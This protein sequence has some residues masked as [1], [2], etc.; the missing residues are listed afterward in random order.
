MEYY[1]TKYTKEQQNVWDDF[2]ENSKNGTFLLKRAYMDYHSDRFQ[3]F[4]LFFYKDNKLIALLPANIDGSVLYS[5]QGLTYGGMIMSTKTT[6][7][8]TIQCFEQLNVFL[9]QNNIHKLIYKTIPYIYHHHPA[10]EDLYAIFKVCNFNIIGR[11]IS[12]TIL[13]NGEQRL[14]FSTLRK[15]GVKKA[16]QSNVTINHNEDYNGFWKVLTANLQGKYQKN[17]VHSLGE[18]EL[19]QKRFPE[20]I[21]LYIAELDDEI[22]AGVVLYLSRKT[23]H[24]QYISASIKGKELGALDLLFDELINKEYTDC[25]YFDFGQSTED[26]GNYLNENLIFQKEGFGGR[27]VVYDVYE[28]IV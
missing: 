11:N 6:T 26:V 20:N 23:V 22:L 21:K 5:H 7:V 13:L 28:I 25:Q 14:K 10:E 4:S 19:L 12:S 8:D 16:L 15:R 9:K 3:D 1:I 27:G 17:P 2:V 18:I 24:V